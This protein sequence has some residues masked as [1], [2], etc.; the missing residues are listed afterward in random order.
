MKQT[1][2]QIYTTCPDLTVIEDQRKLNT[3][4]K[5]TGAS[6]SYRHHPSDITF[7]EKL[8]VQK[9]MQQV[10]SFI[11]M[12]FYL[13]I[14][15]FILF[16]QVASKAQIISQH[17]ETSSGTTPKGIEIWNNTTDTL[18]FNTHNLVIKKG[19][20][21][22]VPAVDFTLSTGILAPN[23]VIVIGTL[24]MKTIT[25][26]NGSVFHEKAFTF[27][28]DDALVVEYGGTVTDMFGT[29]GFDPG[30]AWT[31]NGVSTANQNIA[32]KS[33]I[34]IGD[35]DGWSDPSLRFMVI[36]TDNS[37]TGFGIAPFPS[38]GNI[39]VNKTA[40]SNLDYIFPEGPSAS[41]SFVISGQYLLSD[42]TITP[43][44][45]FEI[46]TNN[47]LFQSTAINLQNISGTVTD[48]TIYVRLKEGLTIGNYATSPLII[49]ASGVSNISIALSGRV[50][51]SATMSLPNCWINEFH[52]ENIG[53]DENEFVEIVIENPSIFNLSD[54]TISLYNGGDGKVYGSST[55]N[56]C[57]RGTEIGQFG[58]FSY[59]PS[60]IQNGAP[61]GF[62]LSYKGEPIQFISYEG[63]F[64]ATNGPAL[65][66]TSTDIGL[67]QSNTGT[68][69]GIT[70]QLTG[71]G[72]QYSHFRW[73]SYGESAGEINYYQKLD[74][75]A[76]A[77]PV[78]HWASVF[79]F[80]LLGT[81][82]LL[83]K[84]LL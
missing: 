33:G 26:A 11:G 3:D 43:P 27:N 48:T 58:F 79:V 77:V 56:L 49:S 63:S 8:H 52:Y 57:T 64:T 71:T 4:E 1:C 55:L 5:N 59:H 51:Y 81:T 23:A 40:I 14:A 20:N 73:I 12:K 28:G 83:R 80:L 15:A 75:Y 82:L 53:T 29:A 67:E 7:G 32:L 2:L 65:G 60:T 50:H 61:D 31:G 76:P 9:E 25:E 70:L 13:L 36:S 69:M 21:G 47:I 18:R 72:N 22:A 19:T 46:S 16:A 78:K 6:A 68:R 35:T 17:I 24:D 37:M 54:F 30:S 44:S 42:I 38:D 62:A 10:R 66:L 84:R 45:N 41:N 74:D 34:S 39:S